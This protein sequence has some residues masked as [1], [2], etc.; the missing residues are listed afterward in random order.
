MSKINFEQIFPDIL[1]GK[2]EHNHAKKILLEINKSGFTADMFTAAVKTLKSCMK[3]INIDQDAIDVCGTG[4]DNLQTLNVSTAVCFV[5]AGCDVPV[6]KHGN[7]AISSNSGSAAIFTELGIG[8]SDDENSIRENIEKHK[9]TFLFA[10]LFHQ[11][12]KGVSTLRQE[13]AKEFQVPTIFNYLGPLLNPVNTKRQLIGVSDRKIMQQ[14][15]K[16]LACDKNITAYFVH[17]FDGMDELTICDNSYLVKVENG[18]VS[19]EQ[20]INPENYG[21][22]KSPIS[23]IQGKDPKYNAERLISM[24][25]GEKSAYRDIVVLNAAFALQLAGKVESIEDGILMASNII[26]DGK[27]MDVLLSLRS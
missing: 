18:Q 12:L 16:S 4:G 24:L 14:M 6:A 1:S 13:I 20:I 9:L 22:K 19:D 27:A 3:S 2:I 15:A 7:K 21:F 23:Q 5:L 8:I 11:S 25:D 26:D 17:G 10:P